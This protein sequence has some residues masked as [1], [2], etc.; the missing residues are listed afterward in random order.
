[1]TIVTLT[2]RWLAAAAA[3]VLAGA[4]PAGAQ[5]INSSGTGNNVPKFEPGGQSSRNIHLL[6][7]IPL[8][9]GFTTTDLEIEQELNRPY[10]YVSRM[11]GSTH[12]AG[13]SIINL[14]DPSHA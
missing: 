11:E 12:S 13:T 3:L 7:H 10:A 2:H 8:G 5:L 1:M 9:R 4:T 6:A 14:K